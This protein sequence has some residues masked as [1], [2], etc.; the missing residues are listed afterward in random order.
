MLENALSLISQGKFEHAIEIFKSILKK[1]PENFKA[2]EEF[3]ACLFKYGTKLDDDWV[4][5]FDKIANCYE[6]LILLDQKNSVAW[7]N[8]GI[9][10][11]NQKKFN[12][13]ID[14]YNK[15]LK[16]QPDNKYVLYNLGLLYQE[17]EDYDSSLKYYKMTLK[18]DPEFRYALDGKKEVK[19]ILKQITNN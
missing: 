10:Y 12:K 4:P 2:K 18:I 19:K 8:L 1:N 11:F 16:I 5:D 9:A 13:A 17:M 14:C 6:E 7:Y 3:I 15:S